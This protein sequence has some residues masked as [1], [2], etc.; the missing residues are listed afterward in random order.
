MVSRGSERRHIVRG[1][2]VLDLRSPEST[3]EALAAEIRSAEAA[4]SSWSFV[5]Y[6]N[7]P[8]RSQSKS[9]QLPA[10]SSAP[11]APDRALRNLVR[12]THLAPSQLVLPVFVRGGRKVRRP[13]GSMPGVNQTSIDEMLRDAE[14]AAK[15]KV[16]GSFS[17]AS[18]KR[19]TRPARR[20]GM[21]R[22]RYSWQ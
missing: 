19:K 7:F 10:V 2:R 12:E 11:P 8:L 3:G 13:V 6:P 15:A 14:A 20:R 4:V 22:A 9:V 17:L 18:R 1:S 5:S 21:K 16:G